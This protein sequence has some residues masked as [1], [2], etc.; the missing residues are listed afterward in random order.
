MAA[1]LRAPTLVPITRSG[2]STPASKSASRVPTWAAPR[3]PPPPRTQVRFEAKSGPLLPGL[4]I[5]LLLRGQRVDA[6]A[7]RVQLQTRH[8]DRKST[9]LNSSH[10]IISYAVFCLKK[11]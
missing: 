3:A 6:D 7:H 8:L 2:A 9:R 5:L 11:K 10:Q 1:A 4:Q